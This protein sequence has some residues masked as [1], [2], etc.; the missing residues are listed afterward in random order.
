[1]EGALHEDGS[2]DD[3][4]GTENSAQWCNIGTETDEKWENLLTVKYSRQQSTI[5]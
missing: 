1:M 4:Y 2:E 3:D 5:G